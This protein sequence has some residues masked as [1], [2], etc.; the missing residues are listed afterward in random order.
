[1]PSL[2]NVYSAAGHSILIGKELGKGGEGS[3]FAI[4]GH[5]QL[6][7]KLYHKDKAADR[8]EKISAMTSARWHVAATNVAFPIEPLF[9][10][11]KHFLGFT[12]R[13]VGGHHP[14]HNLYSP[15]SRKTSFPKTNSFPFLLRTAANIARALA[16]VH[17]TGCVVG[18][19]NH[20]GILIADDATSTLIDCDSFQ[21]KTA[22]KLFLCKVGVPEFTPPELQGKRFDQLP[23]TTNHD[24][25]GLAIIIF[26]LLFMGRHPFAGTFLGRGD[27]P[28]ETA[29]EQF[30][31]AYSVRKTETK[32]APPP[33]VP[34]LTDIPLEMRDAF[35]TA[36]GHVGAT[37]GR[38]KPAD[39]VRL[40]ESAEKQV[41]QCKSNAAHHYFNSALA[42]A[43][44]R[45]EATYPGFV[46]FTA[47]TSSSP[48][49]PRTLTELIAAVRS[50]PDPGPAPNLP[51]AMPPFQ[52][53]ATAAATAVRESWMGRYVVG[54]LGMLFSFELMHLSAPGPLLGLISFVGSVILACRQ[55]DATASLRQSSKHAGA[56]WQTILNKWTQLAGNQTYLTI[57]HEGE[58]LIRR[59][60]LLEG[61]ERTKIANLKIKQRERQLTLFLE[62]YYVSHAKI[63][64]IG[65]GRKATLRSYGIETAADV[66]R[67][68]IE[69]ISGFGPAMAG[70]LIGWRVSLERSFVFN[71]NQP[72]N[73]AD[74]MAIKN[75]VA[76]QTGDVV[77][78]LRKC[79]SNLQQ[80]SSDAHGAR[81]SLKTS[82]VTVWS[83]L[84]QSELDEAVLN[85]KSTTSGRRGAFAAISVLG[86]FVV[87]GVNSTTTGQ[88]S[89]SPGTTISPNRGAPSGTDR[90]NNQSKSANTV[91]TYPPP[92]PE[93]ELRTWPGNAP[94]PSP[95]S[96]SNGASS[97]TSA[98][99]SGAGVATDRG[100]PEQPDTPL[101]T[102]GLANVTP[103]GAPYIASSRSEFSAPPL[104][105]PIEIGPATRNDA[106]QNSAVGVDTKVRNSTDIGA[107]RTALRKA[108]FLV[109]DA[110]GTWD[111]T[112][113]EALRDFKAVNGLA[114]DDI[115]DVKTEQKL[116][117]AGA[118]S[119]S[120]S[121][122][123]RWSPAPS[124]TGD[125]F[126]T[127]PLAIN[128][129]RA[130]S[131][132][133]ACEF[134][135]IQREG[136]GWRVLATC[137]VD[138]NTWLAHIKLNVKA[139]ELTWESERGLARYYRCR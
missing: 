133:G 9:D 66:V 19:I 92:A 60:T 127:A 59:L 36:F 75:D 8:A 129:R 65:N 105:A 69:G 68:R 119:A 35:E 77:T 64:G 21:A 83:Q 94:T 7:A 50:V 90:T 131:V 56:A 44:C 34:L 112:S 33:G 74:I 95:Q 128:S 24:S 57:Q 27:M 82:A 62:R 12:M 47:A 20:S 76:R 71:P 84:K 45:M 101:I 91:P 48:F 14:I 31:F 113:R 104:A 1:M 102:G 124:C 51:A 67:H 79:L 26:N 121:F 106:A 107:I 125:S 58:E 81:T 115:L 110:S 111:A 85:Q 42:C 38:P 15:T 137:D 87:H 117:S 28:L 25:F 130:S 122:I 132:G 23:R 118:I 6:A 49:N 18:D 123:G 99:P 4:E 37:V 32:M 78:K 2:T 29:I 61:E 39:W 52:G 116:N 93:R 108:G 126:N 114:L 97:T 70:T 86:F 17:R 54:I 89:N 139:S 53:Q 41:T 3:V 135:T 103:T 73:P 30:R 138:G 55:T 88:I 96:Q 43:W 136:G 100:R 13:R 22:S 11:T 98:Q 72:I 10:Q 134:Q 109:A 40:I 120:R 63:K 5:S 80:V 46:A 16:D